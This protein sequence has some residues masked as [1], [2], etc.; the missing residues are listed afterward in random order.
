MGGLHKN[1]FTFT[2]YDRVAVYVKF[3]DEAYFPPPPPKPAVHTRD[4]LDQ[5]L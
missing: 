1:T 2:N 5:A 4:D 3:K